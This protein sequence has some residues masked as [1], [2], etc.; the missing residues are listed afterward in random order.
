[1]VSFVLFFVYNLRIQTEFF[2]LFFKLRWWYDILELE[3]GWSGEKLALKYSVRSRFCLQ[4]QF[5]SPSVQ[6]NSRARVLKLDFN[7]GKI[8]KVIYVLFCPP[9]FLS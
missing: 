7:L 6:F 4:S 1:M 5:F 8:W 3:I 9:L 2:H